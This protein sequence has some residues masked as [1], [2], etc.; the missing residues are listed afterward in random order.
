MWL[1]SVLKSQILAAT[2]LFSAA[3][4]GGRIMLVSRLCF[5]ETA[6]DSRHKVGKTSMVTRF[7]YELKVG[8]TMRKTSVSANQAYIGLT[9]KRGVVRQV[10]VGRYSQPS[11]INTLRSAIRNPF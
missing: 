11:L 5:D 8:V 9:V 7:V 10:F 1:L 6:F 3:D 2:R 4:T